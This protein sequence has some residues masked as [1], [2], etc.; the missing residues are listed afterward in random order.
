M[1]FRRFLRKGAPA[2]VKREGLTPAEATAA[3]VAAGG[4]PVFAH[5]GIVGR[6]ETLRSLVDIGLGGIEAYHPEHG[7][8]ITRK[9]ETMAR[10]LG[11]VATGGSDSHGGKSVRDVAIGAVTCDAA[12]VEELRARAQ[13][14]RSTRPGLQDVCR[15]S[16]TTISPFTNT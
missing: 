16:P 9:Y 6:D 13:Q 14:N 10:D 5:P 15:P 12:V 2:Y 11:L 7:P 8:D 3:I 1:A 4:V